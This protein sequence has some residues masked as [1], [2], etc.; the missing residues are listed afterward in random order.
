MWHSGASRN[1][2]AAPFKGFRCDSVHWPSWGPVLQ[3]HMALPAQACA[4][5]GRFSDARVAESALTLLPHLKKR[6]VRALLPESD[7]LDAPAGLVERIPEDEI[8]DAADLV[9]AIG[10]DGTLLYAAR[11]VA[12]SRRAAHRHQPRPAGFPYG[13]SAA[14]HA[15]LGRRRDRRPL[16]T[17]RTLDARSAHRRRARHRAPARSR[18]TTSCCRSGKRAACSTSKPGSTAST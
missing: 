1:T 9:I 10:G 4:L 14:G 16:R 6:G 13:R 5:I 12:P 11:L 18:S 17:R 7:P 2:P 8:A 15:R 3:S